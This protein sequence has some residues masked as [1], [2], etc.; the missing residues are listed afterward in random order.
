MSKAYHEQIQD[1]V[2]N[3]DLD[4]KSK[5]L[6][7]LFVSIAT[8]EESEAVYEAVNESPDNLRLLTDHLRSKILDMKERDPETWDKLNI[9]KPE[10]V[11][12]L[13]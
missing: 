4:A 3:S 13:Q 6:W 5:K 8:E 9:K 11:E 1:V 2:D 10:V 7:Q 12:A